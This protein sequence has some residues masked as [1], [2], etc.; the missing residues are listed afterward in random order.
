MALGRNFSNIELQKGYSVAIVGYEIAVSLFEPYENPIN[1]TISIGSHKYKVIGVMKP[2]G[3]TMSFGG[4]KNCVIPVENVRHYFSRPNRSFLVN[5]MTMNAASLEA[6][7]GEATASFRNVRNLSPSEENNF[8]M[9]KSD[10]L[11]QILIEN[12]KY[13]TLAATLIG[14]ITLVGAAIGLMNIMLVSVTERT[15]EI[16]VRKALGASASLVRQQ[17]LIEAIAICQMGGIMGIILGILIGNGVS[18]LIGGGFIIPWLW[19]FSGVVLCLF[20]GIVSGIYPAIK[21]SKLDPI[22]ALRYE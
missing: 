6:A 4:D 5:V 18:M 14:F 20:V 13:V 8:D 3:S 15:K 16:G 21:A 7:I 10:S 9:I 17:F 2:K 22:E 1:K 11:S 19:I 12:I